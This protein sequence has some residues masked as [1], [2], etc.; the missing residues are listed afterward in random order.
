MTSPLNLVVEHQ[1]DDDKRD[2]ILKQVRQFNDE[3]SNWHQAIRAEGGLPLDIYAVR[4]DQLIGGLISETFW[5][6]LALDY[7]WVAPDHRRNGLGSLLVMEAE[8]LALERQCQWVKVSTFSFQAPDFYHKL[9]YETVGK[10]VDYP[11]GE[12]MHWLR[13]NLASE[14][15]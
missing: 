10:L 1:A 7:L 3:Q 11:P 13:K 14:L 9:G 4:D 5:G 2:F 12:T 8:T 15:R 6:W